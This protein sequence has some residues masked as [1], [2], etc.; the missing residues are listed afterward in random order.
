[1]PEISF[2]EE[3]FCFYINGKINNF[4]WCE[5]DE[6]SMLDIQDMASECGYNC[7]VHF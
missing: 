6:P 4:D 3:A 7:R 2:H 1:M 5:P